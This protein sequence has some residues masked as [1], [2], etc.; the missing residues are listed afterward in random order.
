M[1]EAG[2]S[3][4]R[5]RPQASV[6]R[7]LRTA[8]V[9]AALGDHEAVERCLRQAERLAAEGCNGQALERVAGGA[10]RI[11]IKFVGEAVEARRP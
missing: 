1:G 9:F 7:V 6:D 2:T 10:A 5:A 4:L 11:A 3:W 8:E